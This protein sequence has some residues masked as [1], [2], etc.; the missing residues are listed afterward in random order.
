MEQEQDLNDFEEAIS[1]NV[2]NLSSALSNL[3]EIDPEIMSTDD[4]KMFR[5][6]KRKIFKALYYYCECLPEIKENENTQNL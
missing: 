3:S 6:M 5:R 1:S 4:K 2:A